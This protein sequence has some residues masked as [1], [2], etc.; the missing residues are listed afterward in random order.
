MRGSAVYESL[1][2]KII[3]EERSIIMATKR[4]LEE[5][6]VGEVKECGSMELLRT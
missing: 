6:D 3:V 4:K 2:P 1:V 5:F